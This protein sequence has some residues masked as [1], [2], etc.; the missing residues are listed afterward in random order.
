MK[1]ISFFLALT[2]LVFSFGLANAA[3]EVT[4]DH[5]DGSYVD[6]GT[7]LVDGANIT[8]HLRVTNTDEAGCKYAPS[9]AFVISSTDGA[10]WAGLDMLWPTVYQIELFP[11]FFVD[12]SM[13]NM[14]SSAFPDTSIHDPDPGAW[15]E[16]WGPGGSISDT[17]G[18][19][20]VAFGGDSA[21]FFG[22]DAIAFELS[23]G[24]ITGNGGTICLD[25]GGGAHGGFEWAWNALDNANGGCNGAQVIP[26]WGGPYCYEVDTPPDF[27]PV[28]GDVPVTLEGSHCEVLSHQFSITDPDPGAGAGPDL[29]LTFSVDIGTIDANTGMWSYTG[30]LSEVG[31]AITLTVVGHEN[32]NAL[33][34]TA[35]VN[36]VMTNNAPEFTLGCGESIFGQNGVLREHAMAGADDCPDPMIFSVVN[37]GGLAG[38]VEFNGSTLE[39]TGTPGVDVGT[40]QIEVGISDTNADG[41][42]CIV[43]VTL[44]DGALYGLQIEKTHGSLQG[45]FVDVDVTLI[46]SGGALGGYSLLLAYDASAL[47]F[48]GAQPGQLLTDCGWEYFTYR[49][50]ANGN[51][52]GGCPSGLVSLT[53]IA[54]TNNGPNHPEV[55]CAPEDVSV[56]TLSFLV[57][58]DRTLNC[59]YVPIRFFWVDCTD[60]TLSDATGLTLY[61]ASTVKEYPY[62]GE[63][64]GENL[65]E[66]YPDAVLPTF[67][68]PMGCDEIN[69]GVDKP[70][71]V[72]DIDF[73]N[74]GID[75]VCS[76][77]IDARG[78]L[79]LDGL[80]YTIADAVMYSNY[81]IS[82]ITALYYA[83]D[84]NQYGYVPGFAG[85]IAASDVN[86]DGLTLT[87][88]DLVYL[89]RVVV[90]D[91]LPYPKVVPELA[92]LL[93]GSSVLAV[94]AQMGAAYVV[95]A[96]NN[97]PTLE[98]SN[99]EMKSAFDGVNTRVLVWSV[100]GNT[101]TGEF[102]SNVGN[103]ISTELATA[104]GTPVLT[105]ELPMNFGLGQNYPNPFNPTTSIE[106]SLSSASD[107]SLTIYNVTGQVVTEFN[108][109]ADAG[110]H[111]ILWDASDNASGVYFYK[112]TA[113]NFTETK[114][115]VLMK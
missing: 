95:I 51:C 107:Y 115:M 5:I 83:E 24:A 112:L 28:L 46:A 16:V 113:G 50:G 21:V 72:A 4:I 68:G 9:F 49:Y 114:K 73:I 102:L 52:S 14:F 36:I 55:D 41:A 108:G 94:D 76:D 63:T 7:K 80:G 109:N 37:A 8:F 35:L 20:G 43:E 31:T 40:F 10:T 15:P 61:I 60:N 69:G 19:A 17:I 75:I 45:G 12:Y 2:L 86:A 3:Q 91:A 82:G 56:A 18:F 29:P 78:D 26:G 81:F 96:G 104:E 11:G 70:G 85:S 59:Q 92:N 57:S 71:V 42:T 48:Q 77:S 93:V 101:F 106:L 13:Q 88:A 90:G 111:T 79:N 22:M 32:D 44:S 89:I 105:K 23:T 25:D 99:M 34:D 47:T 30:D 39:I 74:G 62:D 110:F 53:A 64:L 103:V 27:A 6:G 65:M 1:R 66:V 67:T 38:L 87:V 97:V 33:T 98:A 58:N 100:D 84:V 54:E